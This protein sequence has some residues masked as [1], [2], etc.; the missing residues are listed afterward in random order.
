M[1][2]S[3]YNNIFDK[4]KKMIVLTKFGEALD[5]IL[6]EEFDKVVL[7]AAVAIVQDKDRWLL[8]L[9]TARDDRQLKWCCPGG[10]IKRGES[11]E[12]AAVRECR[13]ETGVRCQAIGEAF[14]LPS[15]EEV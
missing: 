15:R 9:S 1:T 3:L 5:R 11:P 12:E 8:G 7:K 2:F 10:H 14:T 6:V 4:D 13:E